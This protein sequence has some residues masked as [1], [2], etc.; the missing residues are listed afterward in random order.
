MCF[1]IAAIKRL[2]HKKNTGSHTSTGSDGSLKKNTIIPGDV[3]T[4]EQKWKIRYEIIDFAKTLIGVKY[5]YGAEWLDCD[6]IPTSVDCSEL[7]EGIYKKNL[8][9]MPDGSQNQFNFCTYVGVPK[10]GDLAFFGRGGH[11]IGRAHV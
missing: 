5:E 1:V 3:L 9:K 4:D 2:M 10:P 11:Q 6:K 7:I 8:L